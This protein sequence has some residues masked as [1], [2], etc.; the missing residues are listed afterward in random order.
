MEDL[1]AERVG[2]AHRAVTH[3]PHNGV[4]QAAPRH[5]LGDQHPL[6]DQIDGLAAGV[7]PPVPVLGLP[8]VTDHAGEPHRLEVVLVEQELAVGG[9]LPPVQDADHRRRSP[10]PAGPPGVR[11]QQR[12]EHLVAHREGAHQVAL[13][14]A[15][16][17]RQRQEQLGE[18]VVV[19]RARG[20]LG[21]VLGEA[22]PPVLGG[23]ERVQ[24][25]NRRGRD[26]RVL[27]GQGPLPVLQP[28]LVEQVGPLQRGGQRSGKGA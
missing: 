5:Q 13:P 25:G 26:P 1:A 27:Q 20:R 6:V 19:G 21:V 15:A 28:E 4:V 8:G 2:H 23:E 7:E 10:P 11:V 3:R 9:N 14:E 24:P 22:Q 12:V 18:R 16:H 17:H